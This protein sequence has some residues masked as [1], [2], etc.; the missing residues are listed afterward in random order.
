MA[1]Y[2]RAYDS[3]IKHFVVLVRNT[4]T[5]GSN[6]RLRTRLPQYFRSGQPLREDRSIVKKLARIIL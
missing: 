5:H 2:Y 6:Y 3:P 4:A 1:N